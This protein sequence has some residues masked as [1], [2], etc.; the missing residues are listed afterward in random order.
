[1]SQL[2]D[3]MVPPDCDLRGLPFMPL[4]VLRLRDSELAALATGDEFR[5]AVLLWCASWHQM[6]ASSLPDDDTLLANYAGFGRNA[7]AVKEFQKVRA[8]A[9]RG[10]V[11]CSDG[12]LYHPLIAEKALEAMER[13]DEFTEKQGNKET[14]QERWRRKV[15]ELSAQIRAAGGTPP[16][17]A[18]LKT[19]EQCLRDAQASQQASTCETVRDGAETSHVDGAEMALTGTETGTHAARAPVPASAYT[20]EATLNAAALCK[21][22]RHETGF[23]K[24]SPGNLELV[25]LMEAGYPDNLIVE[26]CRE[27][28]EKQVTSFGWVSKAVQSRAARASTIKPAPVTKETKP[29]DNAA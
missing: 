10:W 20:H 4:E 3:P 23:S 11:K 13:R 19:L 28:V 27:A 7:Q 18:S 1:M 14:R 5:A 17:N 6:P 22:I 16:R 15:S 2:P 12:R 25:A 24:V 26:V 21:R 9:L 29:W 8:G